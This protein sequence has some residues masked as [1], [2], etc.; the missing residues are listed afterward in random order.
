MRGAEFRLHRGAGLAI[1]SAYRR[2]STSD[3]KRFCIQRMIRLTAPLPRPYA[4]PRIAC[5]WTSRPRF[6]SRRHG[7]LCL[8]SC[9]IG[10]LSVFRDPVLGCRAGS[11]SDQWPRNR[12]RGW[13]P[14]V[15]GEAYRWARDNS[16]AMPAHWGV[17][18]LCGSFRCGAERRQ[19]VPMGSQT[20]PIGGQTVPDCAASR[21]PC[22]IAHVHQEASISAPSNDCKAVTVATLN[23]LCFSASW[24]IFPGQRIV[25]PTM[26]HPS[27][28]NL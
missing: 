18:D 3:Q 27:S 2:H 8:L 13:A 1:T 11:P 24:V 25:R 23:P 16:G 28:S 20:V 4:A 19:P 10:A 6:A 22:E 7:E 26:A 12:C 14:L 15:L 17:V 21:R 5:N 9:S